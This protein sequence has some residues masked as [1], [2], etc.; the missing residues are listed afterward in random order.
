MR[1]YYNGDIQTTFCGSPWNYTWEKFE[2]VVDAS[3]RDTADKKLEELIMNIY[4]TY[5]KT[6]EDSQSE[7][8]DQPVIT[9]EEFVDQLSTPTELVSGEVKHLNLSF[10]HPDA[11][12]RNELGTYRLKNFIHETYVRREEHPPKITIRL[13]EQ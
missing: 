10:F 8:S 4:Q 1:F 5:V 2:F 9:N 13:G 3:D 11:I 12:V 7:T 6:N